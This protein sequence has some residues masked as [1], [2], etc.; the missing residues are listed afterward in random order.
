MDQ[1][2]VVFMKFQWRAVIMCGIL[3]VFLIGFALQTYQLVCE[4]FPRDSDSMK[5]FA[6]GSIDGAG[7]IF[8]IMDMFWAFK[9]YNHWVLVKGMKW[10]CFGVSGLATFFQIVFFDAMKVIWTLPD[11]LLIAL[12]CIIGLLTVAEVCLFVGIVGSH[13][14]VTTFNDVLVTPEKKS[15]AQLAKSSESK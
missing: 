15:L 7:A 3:G 9:S 4:I 10:I 12:Y 1:Q 6:V 5:L 11:I 2:E 8:L 13:Y 14:S